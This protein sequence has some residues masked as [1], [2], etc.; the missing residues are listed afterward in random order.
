MDTE[1]RIRQIE[2]WYNA[3]YFARGS[4]AFRPPEA[5]D[6]FLKRL[7][8]IPGHR[9]LDVGCGSGFLCALASQVG[10]YAFGVDISTI[11]VQIARENAPNAKIKVGRAEQLEYP[12]EFFHYVTCIGSLEHCLDIEKAV[13]EMWRVTK[14]GGRLC[15][16][17]PN[18]NFI[19][20]KIRRGSAG[21]EQQEINEQLLDLA[22]WRHI[23][24]KGG[25][26]VVKTF[27]DR[28]FAH[29]TRVFASSNPL[30]IVRRTA[31]KLSWYLIPLA[32][33]YQFEFVCTKVA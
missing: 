7:A 20:W 13:R 27:P 30:A 5:Y 22:E 6:I 2:D 31:F 14:D 25:L 15:V 1:H 3:R 23:L 12:T 8:V 21:T 18:R 29:R 19:Y 11:A 9:L 33:T 4:N 16:V 17:V 10:L 28:W 26:R 32:L 24:E